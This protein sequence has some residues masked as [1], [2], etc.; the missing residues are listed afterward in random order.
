LCTVLEEDGFGEKAFFH[1]FVAEEGG[2]EEVRGG[3][4]TFD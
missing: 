2:D 1:C 3:T 4:K